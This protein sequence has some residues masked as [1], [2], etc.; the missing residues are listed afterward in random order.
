VSVIP[1]GVSKP[2]LEKS[3]FCFLLTLPPRCRTGQELSSRKRQ[4]PGSS[5]HTNQ[6][7]SQKVDSLERMNRAVVYLEENLSGEIDFKQV[8][9]LALCSEDRFRRMFS[10]KGTGRLPRRAI[11]LLAATHNLASRISK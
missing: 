7:G 1:D 2:D 11:A 9:R 6:K 10:S 8:E 5:Q 3:G 4:F